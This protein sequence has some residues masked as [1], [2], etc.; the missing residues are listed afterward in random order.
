[1]CSFVDSCFVTRI[2]TFLSVKVEDHNVSLNR[3]WESCSSSDDDTAKPT[4]PS[5]LY[6]LL[7]WLQHIL[8]FCPIYKEA[9][10]KT[11]LQ[12]ATPPPP[13][14]PKK[15]G[16]KKKNIWGPKQD[17]LQTTKFINTVKLDAW[18]QSWNTEE[19]EEEEEGEECGCNKVSLAV[20][21]MCFTHPSPPPLQVSQGTMKSQAYT[22]IRT[23]S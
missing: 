13:A 14:P 21:T 19:K 11:W 4:H 8:Q 6:L 15:K 3:F 7:G 12:G 10:I 9:R 2:I 16:E 22:L 1:M 5:T 18:G 20:K 23:W 17:L